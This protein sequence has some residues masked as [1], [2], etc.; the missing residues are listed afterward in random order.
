[1]GPHT[2]E[3]GEGAS[4]SKPRA[5]R[6]PGRITLVGNHTDYTLGRSLTA[7]IELGTTARFTASAQPFV[8]IA[9]SA[10]DQIVVLELRPD[11]SRFSPGS[12]GGLLAGLVSTLEGSRLE[13]GGSLEISGDL[14]IGAGLSSSASLLIT[15]ALA[16]GIDEPAVDLARRCS[17]AEASAGQAGGLLDQLAILTGASG[18]FSLLDLSALSFE[19]VPLSP[20]SALVVVP[21]GE[22]R[23]L[24]AS[25]YAERRAQ[26]AEAERLIGPLRSAS[27]DDL[28][29]IGDDTIRAR[30][31][32]V[33]SENA[34]VLM[35]ASSLATGDLGAVGALMDESHRSLAEDFA[36]STPG[37]DQLVGS[38]RSTPGVRDARMIGGGFGGC[39]LVLSEPGAIAPGRWPQAIEV[40]PSEAAHLLSS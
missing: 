10:S 24:A 37:I 20:S 27:L 29:D 12:L 21:S 3:P 31:R 9:S 8:T 17:R 33:V 11:P 34:R 4:S 32:H 38:L 25:P 6:A 28:A 23:E 14:P 13:V 19:H 36:V 2:I 5:A 16:I 1:M 40:H 39:V 30:A 7:A 22:T 26:C 18:S 15:C 35:A